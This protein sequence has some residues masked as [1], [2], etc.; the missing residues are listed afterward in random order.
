[1]NTPE[2]P[3]WIRDNERAHARWKALWPILDAAI[4]DPVKHFDYVCLYCQAYA[5]MRDANERL[6]MQGKL[7]KDKYDRIVPN[8]YVTV[9]EKAVQQMTELGR[10]L[11]LHRPSSH[12][13]AIAEQI[14][15]FDGKYLEE[16]GD[17]GSCETCDT[18]RLATGDGAA[19]T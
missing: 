16:T 17:A 6:A 3:A 10:M 4:V 11:G 5:D 13:D 19:R 14:L 2:A 18:S 9:A 8:P 7:V 1:M 12:W 15:L